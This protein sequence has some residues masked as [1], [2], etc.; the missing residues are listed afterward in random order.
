[1]EQT[2]GFARLP[3]HEHASLVTRARTTG[4]A[5]GAVT[6]HRFEFDLPVI[7]QGGYRAALREGNGRNA[8]VQ[9]G[10]RPCFRFVVDGD[11]RRALVTR[12]LDFDPGGGGE[13]IEQHLDIQVEKP[14]VHAEESAKVDGGGDLLERVFFQCFDVVHRDMRPGARV[15]Y[16]QREPFAGVL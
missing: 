8:R 2:Y 4:P 16:G 5:A 3:L 14:P 13:F 1:L 7:F 15:L 11:R 10:H 12:F 6:Y 9:F